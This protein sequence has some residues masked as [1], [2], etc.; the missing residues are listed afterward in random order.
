MLWGGG[1]LWPPSVGKGQGQKEGRR[2]ACQCEVGPGFGLCSQ[3]V[4]LG[5]GVTTTSPRR[6]GT[7]HAS[8]L[9]SHL[10]AQHRRQHTPF[11]PAS[12]AADGDRGVGGPAVCPK[13]PLCGLP[14]ACAWPQ[15]PLNS[16]GLG[17]SHAPWGPATPLGSPVTPPQQPQPRPLQ[18]GHTLSAAPATPLSSPATPPA[19][20]ATPVP[21][22]MQSRQSPAVDPISCR[23]HAWA[24]PGADTVE[25]EAE[26]EALAARADRGVLLPGRRWQRAEEQMP[27]GGPVASGPPW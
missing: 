26:A 2:E 21:G 11:L 3:D 27:G 4:P 12:G 9:R 20:P 8:C 5:P 13:T 17:P 16:V 24:R 18:P 6:P 22:F 19:A 7:P 23:T 25:A 1:G 15:L 10:I 14:T